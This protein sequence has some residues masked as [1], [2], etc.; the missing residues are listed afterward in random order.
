MAVDI[1]LVLRSEH[2]RLLRLCDRCGLS[3]RGFHDPLGDLRNAMRAHIVAASAEIYPTAALMRGQDDWLGARLAQ[4]RWVVQSEDMAVDRIVG[5]AHH[6]MAME[7]QH[8]IDVLAESME[9]PERRRM[10]K[11]F[12]IRRDAAMRGSA[13]GSRRRRSQT[14]LYELARRAGV[15]HRS[16]M[17]QAQL[18][19]AIDT[20]GIG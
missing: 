2:R 20:R 1:V 10:G 15:E 6:L 18:Q 12:R 7:E 19:A 5:A 14:E 3:S 8:V 17:T 13:A 4:I 16:R 11:V 9:V